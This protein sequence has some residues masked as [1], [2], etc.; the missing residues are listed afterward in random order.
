[1][2]RQWKKAWASPGRDALIFLKWLAIAALLGLVIGAVGSAFSLLLGWVTEFRMAHPWLLWLLPLG[3]LLI[4]FLY[5]ASGVE[6]SQGTNLVLLA[7]RTE[8]NVP[9]RM[10]PLIFISTAITHLLGGSAGREGAALQLGGSLA[11]Q[12]GRWLHLDQKD[13]HVITLCGMSACFSAVFGTPVAAA[14][15]P[16]E[17]VSVGVMYYAALVPCATAS[18]IAILVSRLF[19]VSAASLAIQEIP[20]LQPLP[21][22][23]TLLLGILCAGVSFLF[24]KALG[25]S[26]QL[27]ARHVPNPYLRIAIGGA[28]VIVLTLLCGTQDCLGAGMPTIQAAMQG[29]ARPE[30]FLL[31]IIHTAR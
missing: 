1:M 23:Q 6:K 8:E 30:A 7:V 17:V 3:G 22:L 19:S 16:L 31:K 24:C 4:V 25:L 10:A 28:L 29:Q 11:Q 15:F 2:I 27:A 26:G 12:L 5:R 20:A 21:L 14:I 18:L 13:M 9:L